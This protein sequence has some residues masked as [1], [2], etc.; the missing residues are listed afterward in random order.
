MIETFLLGLY[1]LY[2]QLRRAGF[3]QLKVLN[4]LNSGRNIDDD[5]LK[6]RNK[7]PDL[8]KKDK[9]LEEAYEEGEKRANSTD[10]GIIYLQY[11]VKDGSKYKLTPKGA[12]YLESCARDHYPHFWPN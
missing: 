6:L 8:R 1:N 10:M 2:V 3:D 9:I 4:I 12:E 11:L 5:F 7:Y